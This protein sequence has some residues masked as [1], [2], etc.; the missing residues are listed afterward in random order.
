MPTNAVYQPTTVSFENSGGSLLAQTTTASRLKTA[1]RKP[2][3]QSLLLAG[4]LLF[5]ATGVVLTSTAFADYED[6]VSN[7]DIVTE[8]PVHEKEYDI[9]CIVLGIFFCL[10]G[11]VLLGKFENVMLTNKILNNFC[12]L[13]RIVYKSG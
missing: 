2:W 9:V 5:V 3:M 6:S 13:H 10:F 11:F 8:M 1:F 12:N 4:G 7:E